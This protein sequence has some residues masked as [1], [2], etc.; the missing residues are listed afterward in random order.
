MITAAAEEARSRARPVRRRRAAV[1]PPRQPR[2]VL[3]VEDDFLIGLEIADAVAQVG[4][5]VAAVVDNPEQA[6]QTAAAGGVDFATMDINLHGR[7]EGVELAHALFARF[8]VRSLFVT[9]YT[10]ASVRAAAEG[11]EPLGWCAK[12]FTPELLA[13]MLRQIGTELE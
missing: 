7:P 10:E 4:M 9:A 11:A 6:L 5:R 8:G 13:A 2:R 3:I 12:P 1:E